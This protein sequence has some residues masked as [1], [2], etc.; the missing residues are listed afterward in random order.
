MPLQQR[1]SGCT[2]LFF[3]HGAVSSCWLPYGCCNRP[4]GSGL[5]Q[6]IHRRVSWPVIVAVAARLQHQQLASTADQAATV[7]GLDHDPT[8]LPAAST[9]RTGCPRPRTTYHHSRISSSRTHRS[10]NAHLLPSFIASPAPLSLFS[11]LS[12][13]LLLLPTQNNNFTTT[14]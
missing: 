3:V 8:R 13:L 12:I 6:A 5:E 1:L 14:I 7:R 9:A 2:T 11:I 4:R 10:I